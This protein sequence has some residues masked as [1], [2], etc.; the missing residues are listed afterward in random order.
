[1]SKSKVK[2]VPKIKVPKRECSLQDLLAWWLFYQ[3]ECTPS[4]EWVPKDIRAW[5]Y[6]VLC[7][8]ADRPRMIRKLAKAYKEFRKEFI[9]PIKTLKKDKAKGKCKAKAI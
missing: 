4:K 8:I 5:H 7:N 9:I 6:D 3:L 1:M 2:G